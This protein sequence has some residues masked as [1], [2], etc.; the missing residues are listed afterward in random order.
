MESEPTEARL[1]LLS[2][3]LQY[4]LIETHSVIIVVISAVECHTKH[5][6]STVHRTDPPHGHP[7]TQTVEVSA[8]QEVGPHQRVGGGAAGGD[9]DPSHPSAA[10][11]C[12]VVLPGWTLKKVQ[13]F[14][15]SLLSVRL[16]EEERDGQRGVA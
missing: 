15:D 2:L 16:M 5:F 12:V 13:H 10:A 11:L 1:L 3:T 14:E 8:G 7:C 4:C 9:V 6:S